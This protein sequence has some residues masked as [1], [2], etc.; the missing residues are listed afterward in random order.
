MV[1]GVWP[2]LLACVVVLCGALLSFGPLEAGLGIDDANIT[3]AY[4]RNLA[5]GHGYVYNIGSERVE[6][7]T[8]LLWTLINT[9]AFALSQRPETVVT[10]ITLVM[11]AVNFGGEA[12]GEHAQFW[13]RTQAS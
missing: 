4:A 12:E 6:G 8:S 2:V 10:A 3:Q 1:R 9:S 13:R 7:S 11:T 5:A